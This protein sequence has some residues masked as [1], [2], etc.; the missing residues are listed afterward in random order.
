MCIYCFV[1]F[2]FVEYCDADKK[3][4]YFNDFCYFI[5]RYD[6][7]RYADARK[8]CLDKNSDLLSVHSQH[9]SNWL[10]EMVSKTL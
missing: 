10:L 2:C 9:E 4:L 5:V 3:W 1:I 8:K 7:Q 6:S